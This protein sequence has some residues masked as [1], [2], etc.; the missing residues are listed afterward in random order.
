MF[1]HRFMPLLMWFVPLS[2][3]AFQFILRLWPSLNMES[4]MLQFNITAAGFGFLASLY[5]YGY[6][7]MQLP[8]AVLLDKFGAKTVLFFCAMMCGLATFL[9]TYTDNWMLACLSR[10][11]IGA[12]SAIGFLG[13]S[14][15]ISEWFSE[16]MYAKMV[17]YSFSVG[18]LGAVYG[19]MPINSLIE[20]YG[21]NKVAYILGSIAI[22]ISFA[23]LLFL[24][25]PKKF[26]KEAEKNPI[27]LKDLKEL[28]SSKFIWV[29][30]FANL[31]MVG[32]LEG[33]ADVWGVS[34][35]MQFYN[36]SKSS[37]AELTSF[38]FVGMLFGGP[39]LAF[40]SDKLG[41]KTVLVASGF[42]LAVLL[43]LVIYGVSS[44]WVFLASIF[45]LIGVFCCYQVIV[46][47]MGADMVDHRL[48]G[49]TIAFLN[50]I[51]MLGG[52]FFHTMV[53][54]LMDLFWNGEKLES[55]LK[56]YS[57][58]N[59]QLA[60]S[61]IPVCAVAGSLIVMLLKNKHK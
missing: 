10:F 44:S 26:E 43:S 17:G 36:L 1:K 29:F 59:C 22:A 32:S 51:N 30:A 38:I 13:V 11:L 27:S 58:L 35:L 25:S 61:V 60:L 6:A 50:S 12:G 19:G 52:S 24:K 45:F 54:S 4:I 16:T 8:I 20:T 37:A 9:F 31:L 56:F 18:L 49:I 21:N 40:F 3:F 57:S 33:F 48:L 2:F 5:Y 23:A 15:V 42:M 47:A 41:K 34:F 7:G 55:G 39:I 53:G 14:K 28:L 46:F